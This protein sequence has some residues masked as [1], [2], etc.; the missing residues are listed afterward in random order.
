MPP[1]KRK[2]IGKVL[3]K[4]SKKRNVRSAETA[5]QR[6]HR[7]RINR[8]RAS[9]SRAAESVGQRENR[10]QQERDRA[11]TSRAAESLE[12]RENRLQ[13]ERDR[14]STSRAAESVGQ[15]ENRLRQKRNRASTSRVAES[16]GQREN[17]LQQ[18]RDRASTSRAAES[19]GQREN[20]LQQERDRAST[21]RAA[22]SLGQRENRLQQE[23]DRASTSRA[24]ESLG[25]RENRLQQERD[26][27]ST[28]R[29]AESLGQRE[30]RL[31]QERDRASTSRAAESVGQRENRLRQNRNRASTSRAAESLEQRENR[32]QQE[33]DRAS[34]S[35]AAESVGQRENRLRQNRN[36]VS[37]SRAAETPQEH[38][39]RILHVRERTLASRNSR[40][41]L[42]NLLLEGFNYDSC[43]NY[44]QHPSIT[45]GQM[46]IVCNY[47]KAKKFKDE[48]PGFCC[49]N[50]KVYLSPPQLP[51]DEL[52]SLMSG[53][54]SESNH[55]LRNIRKYN[56]CFQMTSFGATSFSEESVFP[57]TFRV[58]SQ[59]YHR[60]GSLL[61]SLDQP[62]QFLQIFFVEDAQ[63]E[64]NQRCHFSSALQHGTVLCL[65]RM[66]HRC[67][68]LIKIFKTAL[69]NMPS[70]EYKLVIRADKTPSGEHER[71]FN[72]PQSNDVA[73]V[74]SADEFNQRDIIIQRRS[75]AL[76][77]ISET[78]RSYDPLQYP[79][80]F[81]DGEDGYHFNYRQI[82]QNTG[83]PTNRK[84]SAMSF[85]SYRI[86]ARDNVYNHILNCR[87]LFSQYI[88]DM[89]AKIESERLLYIRLNQKELR[90]EEYI[91][92]R[93]AVANDGM[94]A[95]FGKLVILPATFTGSPRHMHEYTQDAMVFVRTY[96]RPD[97]FITFTCNPSWPEINA[98]LFNGQKPMDRHDL[99]A[100]VFKL[101]LNKLI[102]LITKQCIFG[103]TRCWMFTIEW[104]K[105]GLPHS[106]IL[107]WLKDK[108]HPI[109]IDNVISAEIPNPEED[110]N[111]YEVVIKNMIHGPCGTF[112]IN[113]PCMKNGKCSKN[114]PRDLISDTQT[115]FDGYPRYR[116][117]A[118]ENGGFK[119]KLKGR[120]NTEIEVDN[121]WVVP[122]S[123]LLSRMFKAH[124]NVE[125]CHSV[126]SIKYI[127][128]YVNKGNDMAIFGLSKENTNDEIS[129]YLLG[130]YISSNEA[131]WR[132]LSFP[133]HE[134]HPN[135]VHLSVHLEN[136]QRVYF[137]N[138]NARTVAAAPPNTTLTAFFQL[139]QQDPFAKNLLYPEVP[140]YYTWNASRKSF[141]RRKQGTSVPEH[142]GI[143]A[144]E[145]LGRVY[146]VHPN[147]AECF[148]LRMLLHTVRGPT[149]FSSL[150]CVNGEECRTFRE[151]CQKLGLLEDDQHWDNVLSEA[152]SQSFPEQIRELFAILLTTCNP[153]N[154]QNLW[155]KYRESMSE[156]VLI[157][158][159]RANPTLDINFSSD[160]FNEALLLLQNKCLAINDRTLSQLGL[161]SP[162][163]CQPTILNRELMREKNYNIEQLRRFVDSKKPLLVEDQREAYNSIMDCINK[164]QGGIIFLDA[165]GG[166]GKT[167][168]IN[169]LLAE[170]RSKN[171]IALAIASSGIAATLIAGGRTAHSMLKLPLNIANEQYPT[172][173]ISSTSGQAQ[174]LKSC[175]IIVWDECTMAH[176]HSLEALDRTLRDLKGNNKLMGGILLLLAGDFRQTLPV[177]PRSTPADEINACL[178]A[179]VL[180]KH[181]KNITLRTNLRVQVLGEHSAQNF[182]RKL[183]QIGEGT[184]PNGS[185]MCD[186]SFPLDFGN[187]VSSVGELID[188]VFPNIAENFRNHGW[189]CERTILAPRND[190]VDEINNC[191]QDMLPGS[192]T[193]YN[194]INT[195]VDVDD[196]VNY[197][198]E[199]LNS[200]NPSG[201]PPHHLRLKIGS[202]IMLLRNLDP[203]KLCN[204]T[205]L[206]VKRLLPNVI[207]ATILTGKENGKDWLIPRIPLIPN[208]FPFLFKRLQFPVR[209]AFAI[210]INKAQGQSLKCCGVNLES[211]CFSH[212]QLYVACSR[213]GSPNHLYIY[214]KDGK[215]KNIVHRQ[216]GTLEAKPRS[217]RPS[218]CKSVAVTVSQNVEVI[219][220]LSTH[221]EISARQ[222]LNK[223]RFRMEQFGEHKI[224]FVINGRTFKIISVTGERYVQLLR[225][226]AIPILKDGQALSVKHS[227]KMEDLFISP[228]VP[229][230]FWRIR[231]VK[232]V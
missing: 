179:S 86:M 73:V 220:T 115:G 189:L 63:L 67:N 33:R 202:P 29:A 144:S 61:P 151:A 149:S 79:I 113:A 231:S 6:E 23:R 178:K 12:Q 41:R 44:E 203:P 30:N 192:V 163:R 99:T 210:T 207:E 74:L 7:L 40:D 121:K 184:F 25:Q 232:I 133:I 82:D 24:A 59:V 42:S 170:V 100:R 19:L 53:N 102:A 18:D 119:G 218:T 150:K 166:T 162:E 10:L 181:I 55:F 11:S 191:I 211:P 228:A 97:L 223:R 183:L 156:D 230:N 185:P 3:P 70:D 135:V 180:W 143:F 13:Q 98:E 58:Q 69:E 225:E 34:T 106:H 177:I 52:F 14:A 2:P 15:R 227:C 194:S 81:W 17:R 39:A 47:C 117:R 153:S 213:V 204:G 134:R 88:V 160:I 36:R 64:V 4:V 21:S 205:R 65:Q 72:A 80:I 108:I 94:V 188:K 187:I 83:V 141:C 126:K 76:K 172:C 146:T 85:Y 148:F 140:R 222:F 182:A 103:E 128:K 9:T 101:K 164:Q 224:F 197:P 157:K 114:Y 71:R 137:T 68:Q 219:E 123:P 112:N 175:I 78:H 95:N 145:A 217:G 209:L 173:N 5:V 48:P 46:S 111:L 124:I 201:L 216:T 60:A 158:A 116:R 136:G 127:C 26:R 1:K 27:A 96:G 195:M 120:G 57:T 169:L 62:P 91:H 122:Y 229:N 131:V 212:G 90:V 105:R 49:K 104:Q 56:S 43:K 37:T 208:D 75:N 31:Q 51:P 221:G 214:C 132:I 118:P 171:A 190:A 199:F 93:D 45:I 107:I 174:V 92:L 110:P 165:P 167:F 138:A 176:K 28:S 161:Q 130:R 206:C 20:R 198:S 154:P 89:Y 38:T 159:R 215:T 226:K 139:C 84:V 186:V 77:R 22:E 129:Q 109:Q 200:L 125:Y 50:G 66:F 54:S 35:R 16:V 193:E 155:E 142:E 168:L 196:T 147:N 87:Q 8:E 32:L 152:A